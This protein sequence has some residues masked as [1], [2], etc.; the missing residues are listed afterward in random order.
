MKKEDKKQVKK[1]VEDQVNNNSLDNNINIVKETRLKDIKDP[2]ER[3]RIYKEAREGKHKYN[4]GITAAAT[5]LTPLN[6]LDPEKAREIRRKGAEALHKARG[7]KKSAKQILNEILPLYANKTAIAE[8]ENIPEDIKKDILSHNIDIT[9][10]HLLYL[11]M[12]NQAENGNTK[13][14][15]FIRDTVGDKPIAET[16]NINEI[17]TQADKDLIS[18][19]EK[20]LNNTDK[21]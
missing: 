19:L 2:E 10:Y 15:E 21:K 13:A 5:N 8:N 14:A 11:S 1:Q 17:I 16:R 3:K 9:H 7:E 6:E 4:K 20:R 12:L 18:K